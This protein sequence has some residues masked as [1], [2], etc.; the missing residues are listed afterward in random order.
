MTRTPE[1]RERVLFPERLAVFLDGRELTRELVATYLAEHH[2]GFTPTHSE[3]EGAWTFA[4]VALQERSKL[5][6]ELSMR[7]MLDMVDTLAPRLA[8]PPLVR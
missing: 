1:Q 2:L 4:S 3:V 6:H 7:I 5:R 8:A